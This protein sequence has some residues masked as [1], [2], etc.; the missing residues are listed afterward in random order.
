[1]TKDEKINALLGVYCNHVSI[2]L[3]EAYVV[4]FGEWNN[5]PTEEMHVKAKEQTILTEAMQHLGL[6]TTNDPYRINYQA[7]PYG[8]DI[9]DNGGWLEQLKLKS[10]QDSNESKKVSLEFENLKL[11]NDSLQNEL[12]DRKNKE[13]IDRLTIKNLKLQN[14]NNR[15]WFLVIGAALSYLLSNW[16]D[17]L[18]L[19]GIKIE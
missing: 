5:L 4:A 16:R 7:T 14:R 19:I 13:E 17:T 9:Q 1:M 12:R 10:I 2:P 8:R 6:I 15:V 11:Q 18:S 3:G